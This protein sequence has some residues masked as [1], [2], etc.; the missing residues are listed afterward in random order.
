MSPHTGP[1]AGLLLAAS[2]MLAVS[3][4][5]DATPTPA[6]E[7]APVASPDAADATPVEAPPAAPTPPARSSVADNPPGW[8]PVEF[9]PPALDFGLLEPGEL[10]EGTVRIHNVGDQTLAIKASGTTCGCT[11]TDRLDGVTIAPGD[12]YE[13]SVQMEPKP[14]LGEKREGM[15]IFFDGFEPRVEFFFTAEIAF[16]V[17]VIPPHITATATSTG[18]LDIASQDGEPFRVLYS[19]GEAPDFVDFDPKTQSPRDRYTIRWDLTDLVARDAVPWFWVIE[20][21]R[22]ECPVIDIRVRHS[23]TIPFRPRG[24]PW[25]PKGQRVLVNRITPGEQVEVSMKLE[26]VPGR[27]PNASAATIQSSATKFD[28]ELLEA[29][30]DGQFLE[31][32]IGIT[33]SEDAVGMLNEKV[34]L[35]ASGFSAP[36]YVIGRIEPAS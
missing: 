14:G 12:S 5:D 8:P 9:E 36:L 4:C 7:V 3:G 11:T 13:F 19:N 10:G 26:F 35:F 27:T 24:R 34:D 21:D 29:S 30:V 31:Y 6:T 18:E 15:G 22:P 25:T 20:T 2:L 28:A 33:A 16:P 32:R 1:F 23:S 17:H